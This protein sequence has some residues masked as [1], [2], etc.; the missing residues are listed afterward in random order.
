MMNKSS[1]FLYHR[2]GLFCCFAVLF[3]LSVFLYP[4]DV[5]AA[6]FNIGDK[7]EVYNTGGVGL[8]LRKC[9]SKNN[10]ICPN[11]V[12]MPDGTQM[13][14]WSGPSQTDGYTW[15]GLSGYVN[16]FFYIGFSAENWLRIVSTPP[17]KITDLRATPECDGTTSQIRLNWT[18]ASGA[19]SYDLYR[20]GS[21]YSPNNTETQFIN[22]GSNVVPG[23]TYTYYVKAK[24]TSGSTDSNTV[25][26]KAPF[27]GDRPSVTTKAATNVTSN[28]ASLSGT[29]NANGLS[30][31]AWYEYGT[32]KGLYSSTSTSE[33]VNGSSDT[34]INIGI[35]GLS[36]GT[37]YYYTLV[38]TNSAGSTSG[39]EMTFTT[40][41]GG[42][43]PTVTV[44]S[45]NGG[46]TWQAGTT[47]TITW[48]VGGSTSNINYFWT[49]Y[50]TDGGS[51]FT[52]I[53]T[54]TPSDRSVS[55]TIPNDVS[56]TQCRVR[57]RALDAN[58][59]ILAYGV[60]DSNFTISVVGVPCDITN[61]SAFGLTIIT[62][63][64]VGDTKTWVTNMADAINSR[65][66]GNV[67]IYTIRIVE[68]GP[69]GARLA[70]DN[71]YITLTS[72]SNAAII[73]VDWS[74]VAGGVCSTNPDYDLTVSTSIIGNLISEYLDKHQ[75]LYRVPIHLIG[76]SRGGSVM[77]HLSK[78]L[79]EKG[80]W[81]D[82]LTTLDPRP[83][84]NDADL[85]V[86]NNVLFADNYYQLTFPYGQ[87][88]MWAYNLDLSNKVENGIAYTCGHIW[89]YYI[90]AHELI[91]TYYHGTI[92]DHCVDGIIVPQD[93]YDLP[94]PDRTRTGYYFTRTGRG[95]RWATS[96]EQNRGPAP[97]EGL[98]YH[99]RESNVNNRETVS[100]NSSAWSN[101]L[102]KP[103]S[104]YNYEIGTQITFNYYYQD[105][106][107]LMDIDVYLDNDT[108]P[109]NNPTTED[110]CHKKIKTTHNISSSKDIDIN[111]ATFNWTPEDI[112]IGSHYVQI[113]ATDNTGHVR[114]DYL[115]KPI[116]VAPADQLPSDLVV[117]NLSVTPGSGEPGSTAKVSFTIRN[118]G[119][120]AYPSR[121]NIRLSASSSSDTVNDALL[122]SIEIPKIAK[123]APYQVS[124]DVIIPGVSASGIY[125]VWVI[126]D[127][128]KEANQ[129]GN[130]YNDK[131]N[132]PFVV[133]VPAPPSA[134]GDFVQVYNAGTSGLRVRS[135]NACDVP[136]LIGKNRFDDAVGKVIDGPQTCTIEEINYTMWKIQWDDC[137][138]G[139]SA[140]NWL[141]K[142]PSAT[143]SCDLTPTIT[144]N[145]PLPD[146]MVGFEYSRTLQ[147]VGGITPY[148][149]SVESG[150]L[151]PGLNLNSST[152][153]IS[154]NS[155]TDGTY[156]FRIRVT[157]SN[158][159]YSEKDFS[160]AIKPAPVII[161]TLTVASSNPGSGVKVTVEVDNNQSSGTTPFNR[162]FYEG[163]TV[164]LTA[165]STSGDNNFQKW[166][167]DGSNAGFNT[168]ITVTMD[169][170]HTMTAVYVGCVYSLSSTS[171]SFSSNGGSDKVDV[172]TSSSNCSWTAERSTDW[173]TITDGSSGTGNGTVSYS[174]SDYTGADTRRGT[175]TIEGQIFTVIQEG[176]APCTY[177]LS[178]TS[179]T[180]SSSGGEDIVGVV[181]TSNSCTWTASSDANWLTFNDYGSSFFTGSQIIHYKV[182]ANTGTDVRKGT[183]TLAEKT[184]T[185]TQDGI[186]TPTPD[187]TPPVVSSTDPPAGA[188]GVSVNTTIN[189]TFSESMDASTISDYTLTINKMPE[190]FKVTGTVT[191]DD[192]TKKATFTPSENLNYLTNYT[193]TITKY[194]RDLAGNPMTDDYQ[195]SFTT[196]PAPDT[197]PPTVSS[198]SPAKD[199]KDV[200]VDTVITAIFSEEMDATTINTATFTVGGVTGT[201]DYDSATMTATF[202]PV[203]NL[204][205]DTTYTATIT[206][207]VTDSAGNH[208]A[209]DYTRSFTTASAPDTQPPTISSTSPAK[210][211]KDV[212]ID[213]VIT[214]TFSEA[215]DAATINITT[216]IVSTGSNNIDGTVAYSDMTATFTPSAPLGYSTTY[217][218]SITT[219]VTD[220]AGNAMTSDYTWSFTTGSDVIAHY[221]FDEGDGST[222]N[223]SSGNGNDGTI[224]GATWKTGKEGGGLSFDGVN[225]YVTIPCMN[226]GE[227]SVGAWFY[228]NA[229][230]KRRN[231]A[232]FSGF[233][234]NS[235]L[236]LR[237]GL[238]FRFPAG[239]PN[240]LEFVLMTQDG[241]GTKTARTT[242]QNLLNAVGS[243]YHA[244]GTY[245]KTTGQQR[246]YVNGE[247]VNT[248]AHP[249]G[250]TVVPL[251]FYPD[252]RI[253]HSRVNNGYFNGVIDDVR[254]YSRAIADHE[255]KGLYTAFTS[256]LQAQYN[257]DEGM[258]TIAGDSSGNGNH[259]RINGGAKWTTGRYGGGLRFDGTNDYVSI[260]R[261]DHDEVSVCAWFKKNGND[262]AR[263]DAVF[264]GYRNNSNVQLREGFDVRFAS[265]S[266]NT[267]DF[268]LMTQDGGG[269]RTQRVTRSNLGNSVGSWYHVTGTYNKTTGKQR[270]YVNGQLVSTQ[271]HPAGNTIVPL[272]KYPDIRIG[273]SRVNAGYFKGVIDDARIYNRALTDQE[274]LGV[275]TGP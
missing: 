59:N 196:A 249:A 82:Q 265:G 137:L 121:T 214:A 244:V 270:L 246:L 165:P 185:V 235:N 254:L 115:V 225:D 210:D 106:D 12:T 119:D 69:Q 89:L 49:A 78:R 194:V 272:T 220:E 153:A 222:A 52:N 178:L 143:I 38:A 41:S 223:D 136:H 138:I 18:A 40:S 207:D 159:L 96:S 245:N 57:V 30:T 218:A 221:T 88:M 8:H 72:T 177:S 100:P 109:F 114:Y 14:V 83:I 10:T 239:V 262:K 259:G 188:T 161:R 174:V 199:A 157:G 101:A 152:G 144:T 205:Y 111:S 268:V 273:Y 118:N 23:T 193:A 151:P 204:S 93:W 169:A 261:S 267:L 81:V 24:N 2:F 258:G 209:S 19:T 4:S 80:I 91:H 50:S 166:Q 247:L 39:N 123:G 215:M 16:N 275:Y 197:Q 170:D 266:P 21:L 110:N 63:G 162:N 133:T 33:L 224:N 76:H 269:N 99:L 175:M 15:W 274:V 234:N 66:G 94:T 243:W 156:S 25:S 200:A 113:I 45:P 242:R 116:N 70:D 86:W 191:Y 134:I 132:Q 192:T 230:D 154:G 149:W 176:T 97:F 233:R 248:V 135:P 55:W 146:G 85:N 181:A 240:T 148:S 43:R 216:F 179:K 46:E 257:L 208:M 183:L 60:S 64:W 102:L 195:W 256:E 219:G 184:F 232:I 167:R 7:V 203:S 212:A 125:Y 79:G 71:P 187:T 236:Q 142:I 3:S 253:G 241:S 28:S 5:Y 122:A 264:G 202:K 238:E 164:K 120:I 62:H 104:S 124:Q 77:S 117:E 251:T 186:S 112:D 168:E 17:G 129:G 44:T 68:G 9:A 36:P 250:N 263:N 130:T 47:Q 51:S 84:C 74:D 158:S 127:V 198:T 145:S 128:N 22:R 35:S 260:P 87:A 189:A 103:L 11:L 139:W 180:F 107:S 6:I 90:R 150:S 163:T 182:S 131:A 73:K 237:Q 53:K 227:V 271:T 31:V 32:T 67:A 171:Q 229:N 108:N 95:D 92:K 13:I 252:M 61:P 37:T 160:L 54:A 228:K 105:A 155:T 173:I 34:T 217:T 201:V 65:M 20:D 255:V 213:T 211:T 1:D 26:A 27:C 98:H 42:D 126:L 56:S 206:N 141:K 231:D 190:L 75:S 140:Q 29:V 147:V 48:S 226:N 172:T 58:G